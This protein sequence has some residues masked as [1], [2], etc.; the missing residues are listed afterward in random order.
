[1]SLYDYNS[2]EIQQVMSKPMKEMEARIEKLERQVKELCEEIGYM[3]L[4]MRVHHNMIDRKK[5]SKTANRVLT[6][7]ELKELSK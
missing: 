3:A 4:V 1:M 6:E 2:D 7:K 5:F